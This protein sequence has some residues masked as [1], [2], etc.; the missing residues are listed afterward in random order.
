MDYQPLISVIIPVYN[1]DRYLNA[2]IQSVLQQT[3]AVSE[4]IVANDGSTDGSADV[5]RQYPQVTLIEQPNQGLSSIR[6]FG[7]QHAK[8]EFIAF[9]DADD[10][11][12]QN[13]LARQMQTFQEHPEL[14]LLFA[15]VQQF[16]SP[17]LDPAQQS[18]IYCPTEPMAGVFPTTMVAR[19]RVFEQVGSFNCDL[20]LGE[21]IDWFSRT[22]E[23]N[24]LAFTLP[25][26]LAHR[27]IHTSNT[28]IQ[29]HQARQDYVH[30]VK[31]ALDRRRAQS[32]SKIVT[33]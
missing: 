10:L 6:N 8:E 15:L 33:T 22:Q 31:A 17:E 3:Y 18:Q 5:A 28:G 12:E 24:C 29:Q 4:I 7:V 14:D 30:V 1:C 27:R 25:E 23:A 19:R 9:L 21:F 32:P 13:K 2:A 16:I 20:V 11:W 26:T